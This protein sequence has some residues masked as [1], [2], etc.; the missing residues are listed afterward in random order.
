M[1]GESTGREPAMRA[2]MR[3]GAHRVARPAHRALR[4]T[5][6]VIVRVLLALRRPPPRPGRRLRVR[7]LLQHAHGTGG[8]IRTVL[9][10]SGHLAGEHD[11]EI[12]SVFRGSAEPFFPAPPRVRIRFVEDRTAPP[13][14][15]AARLLARLPSVITPVDDASFRHM[16]LWSDLLLIRALCGRQPDVLI[17]TRPSL[18]LLVAELAPRGV[19]TVGQ[20]HMNLASYR[21]G[22]RREIERAY[23][24]LTAVSVLTERSR[25][26]YTAALAG[27]PTR[28]VRI[29]NAL[30]GLPGGPSPRERKVILAAGR[31]TRQ[32]GF[33]LLVRAYEP[34]AADHPDWT[35]HIFG[36]GARRDRLRRLITEL[37][38]TGRVVLHARTPD[39]AGEM[40]RASVYVLSS[41]FEGMPMVIIEAMSKG[42]PVVAFDC[43]TGPGEMIEDGGNGLLVPAGDVAG[44]TAALRGLIEDAA[45]RDRLGE[46]ALA[47]SGAYHLDRVG[48]RWLRLLDELRRPVPAPVPGA[49]RPVGSA[50][51]AVHVPRRRRV[52][53][54]IAFIALALGALGMLGLDG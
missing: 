50:E 9:N 40:E 19:V 12:L 48:P 43:P 37:G 46:S 34:L 38:L 11:V 15:R 54:M 35:L 14:G 31:L 42:L 30:P 51:P 13:R 41:R 23:R 52:L 47:S 36:S 1:S 32:K 28:V 25:A 7:I 17:G 33:D 16:T 2:R 20:D 45:L 53:R 6:L 39:L 5:V 21:P 4:L 8:T 10:L 22:L 3:T 44:L 29:P 18:N 24:R 49:R 26:D 27:A